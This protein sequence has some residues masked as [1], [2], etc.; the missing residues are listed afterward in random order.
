MRDLIETMI[1]RLAAYK[2]SEVI[3][4]AA[5]VPCFGNLSRSSIATLGINPSNR[6]FVDEAGKELTDLERRFHTLNSLELK[7]WV[8]AGKK[9]AELILESCDEYFF[10][11]PYNGWFKKLDAI[12]SGTGFSYY[13]RFFPACHIDLLP[14]ATESKWGTLPVSQRKALLQDN[15][16]LLKK[17][18]QGSNLQYLI[19]NGQSVVS[20]F[21]VAAGISLAAERVEGWQLPRSTGQ[22]VSGI[23]YTG[24][25][26]SIAGRSLSKPI[27]ILGFNHNIQSSFGVTTSV[28]RNIAKWVGSKVVMERCEA[29]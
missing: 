22:G 16:D 15:A 21:E 8:H 26:R 1:E 10:R 5:P 6:E 19:L 27:T 14:F 11:N 7:K 12:I 23:A 28:V 24:V 17:L 2:R 9:E 29:A 25:C 3:S 13:D 4:W 18:I 20:E